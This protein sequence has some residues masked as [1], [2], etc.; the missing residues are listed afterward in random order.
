[1][2]EA[3]EL[4]ENSAASIQIVC[5]KIGYEDL[6]GYRFFQESVRAPRRHNAGRISSPKKAAAQ[7]V[8]RRLASPHP[9]NLFDLAHDL[10]QQV[11]QLFWGSRVRPRGDA[12][13]VAR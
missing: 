13:G 8:L 10:V 12:S 3:K 2:S 11:P 9:C 5:S 6:G 4:L 7:P 1:V